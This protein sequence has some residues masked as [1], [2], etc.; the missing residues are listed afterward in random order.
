[1]NDGDGAVNDGCPPIAG[2]DIGALVARSSGPSTMAAGR[3]GQ[4]DR[5]NANR[6]RRPPLDVSE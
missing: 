6:G 2:N 3:A 4:T 5:R 1:M